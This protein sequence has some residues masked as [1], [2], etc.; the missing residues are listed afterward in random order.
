MTIKRHDITGVVLA[1]GQGRR[2]GGMDK[3]WVLFHGE[4]LVVHVMR[5]LQPQ[6]VAA[7]VNAN[8]ELTRY[9][10]LG[11]QVVSDDCTE[12]SVQYA[13]PLAGVL[14][15]MRASPTP[16]IVT[17]PCD[18]PL[19]PADLV[20]R[21]TAALDQKT[22]V[23]AP[24]VTAITPGEQHPQMHPV[25]SLL[26]CQL[27]GDLAAYLEGGGRSMRQ[28]LNQQNALQASFQDATAFVNLNTMQELETLQTQA[29]RSEL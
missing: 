11:H 3:G 4:P 15:A 18:S 2:M 23:Q 17:V 29:D 25:F 26:H 8:R 24:L 16:W 20:S 9:R 28:W 21:M 6:V 10:A 5:R 14:A 12:H 7:M 13:G 19:L 22:T 27:K 1:G